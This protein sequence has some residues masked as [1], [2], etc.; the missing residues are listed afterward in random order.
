[1]KKIKLIFFITAKIPGLALEYI[2]YVIDRYDR[3]PVKLLL[4]I[5]AGGALSTIPAI[6]METVLSSFNFFGGIFQILFHAF[7]V[8]SFSEEYVKRYVVMKLAFFSEH[9]DEKID[10]IVYCVFSALGFAT[11]ENIIYVVFRFSDVEYTGLYRGILSVPAHMLFAV[12]MGYYISLAKFTAN[13]S[14]KREYYSKSLTEPVILHGI[15]DYI[16]M[17]ESMF[18]LLFFI[19]FVLYMWR[20]NLKKLNIYYKESRDNHKDKNDEYFT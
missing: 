3:E 9:F 18:L 1:M 17:S 14:E 11:V 6:F 2:I 4:K 5:F 13:E 12:T 20:N 16:L 19:P 10:G 8:V 7:V 15:F